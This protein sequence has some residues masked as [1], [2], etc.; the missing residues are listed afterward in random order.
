MEVVDVKSNSSPTRTVSAVSLSKG[1]VGCVASSRETLCHSSDDVS[2][3]KVFAIAPISDEA[4]SPIM[5]NNLAGFQLRMT[6]GNEEG[7]RSPGKG[8]HGGASF[9]VANVPD[10][11]SSE[12]MQCE[13]SMS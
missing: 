6:R 12:I 9:V 11:E 2:G 3:S 7:G 4:L 8:R 1:M 13:S 10:L 5:I